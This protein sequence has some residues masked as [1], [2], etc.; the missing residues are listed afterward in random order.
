MYFWKGIGQIGYFLWVIAKVVAVS[1]VIVVLVRQFI[2]Q[3]FFVKGASMEPEFLDGEYLVVDEIS[4][5]FS[6]VERGQVVIF[7]Y[8]K[9]PSQYFIKRVIGLPGETV[10]IDEGKVKIESG[11]GDIELGEDYLGYGVETFGNMTI[12]LDEEQYFVLG[13]NR[14]ASSDSRMWGALPEKYLVGRVWFRVWPFDRWGVAESPQY[15]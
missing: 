4:Y 11:E 13:D 10:V 8:P 9:D 1:L 15:Q 7:R 6:D 2:V 12:K 14:V 5:R 3:P